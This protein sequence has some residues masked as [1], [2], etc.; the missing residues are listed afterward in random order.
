M[1]C[2]RGLLDQFVLPACIGRLGENSGFTMMRVAVRSGK[3][4][5]YM[6]TPFISF[7][8]IAFLSLGWWF[9]IDL[10]ISLIR[11]W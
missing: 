2:V 4:A 1:A 9:Q 5:L 11:P 8:G 3:L 6:I 10:C 7:V